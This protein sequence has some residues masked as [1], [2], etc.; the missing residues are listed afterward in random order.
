MNTQRTL[1]T[2]KINENQPK[3]LETNPK[4]YIPKA[5]TIVIAMGR[6]CLNR[7]FVVKSDTDFNAV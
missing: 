1:K 7:L 6:Y 2:M 4:K 3:Q 5:I